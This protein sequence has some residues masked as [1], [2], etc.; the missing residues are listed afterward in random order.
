M[1]FLIEKEG[2]KLEIQ[3]GV[4]KILHNIKEVS[5]ERVDCEDDAKAIEMLMNKYQFYLQHVY[6][7]LME[8]SI[9]ILRQMN[10]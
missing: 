2:K 1:Q 4:A 9:W 7:L 10:I 5:K 3:E 6:P 8:S